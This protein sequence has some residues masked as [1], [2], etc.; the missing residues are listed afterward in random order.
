MQRKMKAALW[1][2]A[3]DLVDTFRRFHV[4]LFSLRPNRVAAQ[5]HAVS[6][7][8]LAVAKDRQFPRRFFDND[9]ISRRSGR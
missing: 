9:P 5:R 3:V 8:M 4:A 7:E 6:L 2:P 1:I